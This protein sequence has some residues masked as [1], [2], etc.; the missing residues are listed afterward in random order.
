MTKIKL[1]GLR[2]MEDVNFVN[3]LMPDY[4]GF[5]FAK[6]KWRYITLEKAKELRSALK[7]K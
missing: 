6:K 4:I 2:R 7:V 1:C 3:E 5:I